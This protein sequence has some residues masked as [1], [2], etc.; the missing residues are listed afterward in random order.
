MVIGS[1]ST[2]HVLR[3]QRKTQLPIN[4]NT[5]T[6]AKNYKGIDLEYCSHLSSNLDYK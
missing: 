1:N 4:A 5:F 2:R 6:I 3:A